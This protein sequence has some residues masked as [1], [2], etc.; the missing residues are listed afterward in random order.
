VLDGLDSAG[1]DADVTVFSGERYFSFSP[2]DRYSVA[3]IGQFYSS[4]YA[5][6]KR[7]AVHYPPRKTF[8]GD[9]VPCYS[10]NGEPRFFSSDMFGGHTNIWGGTVLP[11]TE[12]D[13]SGWPITR[14]DLE[15]H[16][17]AIA[18]LIGIAGRRDQL[19]EFLRLDYANLPP[20][21]QL[22][23]FRHLEDHLN[24][25]AE[26]DDYRFHAGVPPSAIDTRDGSSTGCIQCGECMVGCARDAIYSARTALR[27][28]IDSGSVRF[29]A[30]N[31]TAVGSR[32]GLPEVHC[33]DGGTEPFDRVFLCAGCVPTTEILMR[34]LKMETG[35]ILQDNCIYQFP[36]VNL[37]RH[38]D[39]CKGEYFGLTNLLLLL[40]PK[41]SDLPL[42]QMHLYPN[43]DYLWRTLA[44]P[45]IW[46]YLRHPVRWFRD[47]LIWARVY[48]DADGSNRYSVSLEGDRLVFGELGMPDDANVR[49]CIR[50][51]RH[52][53][54]G[55][56]CYVLPFTPVLAHT[57]AHVAGTFPYGGA[58]VPVARDGEVIPGVH[59]ADSACF[60]RSPVISPTLTIMANARRTAF[61]A[62]RA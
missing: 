25:H 54:R 29:V 17:Q 58:A 3:D 57:S 41:R 27:Q 8:F 42:L 52:V 46:E 24:H 6:I 59:I 19:A 11:L 1:V 13:F 9:T 23:G 22:D 28:R 56:A 35:P 12:P 62:V 47:R 20:L 50:S 4:V 21:R 43:V 49:R 51:L 5:D 31:V 2:G 26:S 15:P 34:S 55:S 7:Q 38:S 40:E 45:W 33:N 53:L 36:L 18:N 32:D 14:A 60:P 61:E 39:R 44:S 30:R 10:V 16:Y 37:S 48:M